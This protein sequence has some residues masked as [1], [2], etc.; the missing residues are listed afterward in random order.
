MSRIALHRLRCIFRSVRPAYQAAKGRK[1][2]RAPERRRNSGARAGHWWGGAARV[3]SPSDEMGA[4]TGGAG[5]AL[6]NAV[7][8]RERGAEIRRAFV[9]S[10]E[11]PCRREDGPSLRRAGFP[12]YARPAKAGQP[13]AG[14]RLVVNATGR[15]GAHPPPRSGGLGPTRG[16]D[17][18]GPRASMSFLDRRLTNY[19]HHLRTPSNGPSGCSCLLPWQKHGAC[20]RHHRRRLLRRS[21]SVFATDRRKVKL[22]VSKRSSGV[23]PGPW[24]KRARLSAT[25]GG[26]RP[27]LYRLWGPN[28]DPASPRAEHQVVDPRRARR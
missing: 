26:V 9:V 5:Y 2:P 14:A 13:A 21:R 18:P 20:P 11:N 28:E 17:S 25:W 15:L 1:V 8:A 7:D 24:R 6:A 22:L 4:S 23:F 27:T 12:R 19:R 10:T 16:A 3:A